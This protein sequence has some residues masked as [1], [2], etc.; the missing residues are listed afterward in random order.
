[1][2]TGWVVATASGTATPFHAE[3]GLEQYSR[4]MGICVHYCRMVSSCLGLL[5][6]SHLLCPVWAQLDNAM[7]TSTT[8]IRVECR[9]PVANEAS[10]AR[11]LALL[12]EDVWISGI[13][14]LTDGRERGKWHDALDFGGFGQIRLYALRSIREMIPYLET[15]KGYATSYGP[16]RSGGL[17]RTG[18]RR[19]DAS[20]SSPT[21][22]KGHI[23]ELD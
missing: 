22:T 5:R 9:L 6:R 14:I 13:C 18:R 8:R 1:M 17:K 19:Q 20:D 23:L 4:V 7:L 21:A 3:T 12:R 16:L 15:A 10:E 11:V 2:A